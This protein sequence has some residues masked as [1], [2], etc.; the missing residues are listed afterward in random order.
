MQPREIEY[1]L[2]PPPMGERM[3]LWLRQRFHHFE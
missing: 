1:R 3:R 2:Y